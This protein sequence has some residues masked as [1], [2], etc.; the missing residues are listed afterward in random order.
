MRAANITDQALL[1]RAAAIDRA[2]DEIFN[3]A[4]MDTP[5]DHGP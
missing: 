2:G 4:A 3:N 1:L 5:N